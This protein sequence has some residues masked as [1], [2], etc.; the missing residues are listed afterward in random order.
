MKPIAVSSIPLWLIA[1][2]ALESPPQ[3]PEDQDVG[4]Q[5]LS[6]SAFSVADRDAAPRARHPLSDPEFDRLTPRAVFGDNGRVRVADIDPATGVL[7]RNADLSYGQIID[8][9][10]TNTTGI[11]F[12]FNGA[13][14]GASAAGSVIAYT[15]GSREQGF[16]IFIATQNT[17]GRWTPRRAAELGDGWAPI[18][19]Q[20]ETDTAWSVLFGRGLYD[21]ANPAAV[22]LAYRIPPYTEEIQLSDAD[23]GVGNGAALVK[24]AYQRSALTYLLAKQPAN[25]STGYSQVGYH[26]T[27]TRRTIAITGTASNKVDAFAWG[28]P[29][30]EGALAAWALDDTGALEVFLGAKT[31][32]TGPLPR[33]ATLTPPAGYRYTSPE[34]FLFAGK[35]YVALLQ[36]A[37]TSGAT[38]RLVIASLNLASTRVPTLRTVSLTT[39]VRRSEPEPVVYQGKAF[40]YYNQGPTLR[41][42]DTKLDTAPL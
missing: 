26:D 14:W 11:P 39:D 4:G 37:R 6:S 42:C 30:L 20:T 29:E 22:K 23:P 36:Q 13:E 10:M 34:P 32:P 21:A 3:P 41:V 12:V 28:A 8:S 2:C 1:S 17:E 40:V 9:E 38:D 35:S 5:D 33:V 24:W 25:D 7:R 18:P 19:S 27:G 31:L 15:K 16:S